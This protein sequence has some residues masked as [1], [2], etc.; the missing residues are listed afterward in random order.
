MT[1]APP[2]TRRCGNPKCTKP[3]RKLY[4]SDACRHTM[5]QLRRKVFADEQRRLARRCDC[6]APTTAL[7]AL[8]DLA[9]GCLGTAEGVLDLAAAGRRVDRW[10]IEE[11]R[12]RIAGWLAEVRRLIGRGAA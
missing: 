3:A 7:E 1:T 6:E 5:R 12:G 11:H 4:C 8:V 10:L 9:A 2:P